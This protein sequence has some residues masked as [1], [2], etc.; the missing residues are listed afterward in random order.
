M[1]CSG[2]VEYTAR[3]RPILDIVFQEVPDLRLVRAY[4]LECVDH[5]VERVIA[6]AAKS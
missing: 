3:T 6:M 4:G 2:H 5:Q 1:V